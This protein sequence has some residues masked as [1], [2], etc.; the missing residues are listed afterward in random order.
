MVRLTARH[1]W[2]ALVA[3]L[4]AGH[5]CPAAWAQATARP[6]T[7]GARAV[8]VMDNEHWELAVWPASGARVMHAVFKPT[9]HDWVFEKAGLFFGHVTQQEA[10]GEFLDA[11]YDYRIFSAGLEQALSSGPVEF[12]SICD[13]NS[14]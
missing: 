10:P 7:E 1:A 2:P 13:F 3:L 6:D 12:D 9:G 14:Q 5:L 4:L 11:K 8:V